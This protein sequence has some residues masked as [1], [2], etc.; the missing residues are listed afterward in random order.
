MSLSFSMPMVDSTTPSMAACASPSSAL[1]PIPGAPLMTMTLLVPE[2]AL[3][4]LDLSTA[5]S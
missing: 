3:G 1:L 5:S 2:R 4:K